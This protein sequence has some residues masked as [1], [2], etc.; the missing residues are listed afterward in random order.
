MIE[1]RNPYRKTLI[2]PWTAR[3][4]CFVRGPLSCR[5]SHPPAGHRKIMLAG[6]YLYKRGRRWP[7]GGMLTGIILQRLNN[8]R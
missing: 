2:G 6:G 4:I 7:A 8:I 3:H 1:R 5:I